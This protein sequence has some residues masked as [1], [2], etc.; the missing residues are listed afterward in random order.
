MKRACLNLRLL[1]VCA[2][3]ILSQIADQH[4]VSVDSIRESNNLD[5]DLLQIDQQLLIPLVAQ[6]LHTVRDGDAIQDIATAHEVNT[7]KPGLS[8]DGIYI[9][10]GQFISANNENVGVIVNSLSEPYWGSRYFAANR[11]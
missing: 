7:Y 3:P 8:H 9:G 11:P 6:D 1:S 4:Q 5:S 2:K 10:D